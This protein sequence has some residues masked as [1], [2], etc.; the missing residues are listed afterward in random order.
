M[1]KHLLAIGFQLPLGSLDAYLHQINTIPLL[2]LEEEQDLAQKLQTSGDLA[3]AQRLV[4]SHIRY[5]ARIAKNYKGYGLPLAD[6]IQEGTIGL[7]KAVK[8]FDPS[9]GVRL[10]S[11]AVHWIK[12]EMHEFILKN[13]RI[14]K[15]ATTKA[16][17]KLFFNLRKSRKSLGWN[18]N[19]EVNALAA[20]LG[21]KPEEV[22]NMEA[23]L[24]SNDCS[25]DY[26][27]DKDDSHSSRALSPSDY[28][29]DINLDPY[30][31]LETENFASKARAAFDLAFKSLDTRSQ[32]ILQKRWLSGSEKATL[33]IG[34]AS[35]R[36]R[37][38][39]Y[40]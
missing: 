9:V 8:R 32:A 11:F 15:I 33:Q 14:V 4:M 40:V 3:A 31:I 34:R 36:E 13:W 6:L 23:R 38:C 19:D 1:S 26:F 10:V 16:Q 18:T 30:H 22:R 29:V 7:M 28:L 17:R 39:L 20:D 21:V 24:N 2:T 27:L 35:C 5:V 37:V 12:A 25:F